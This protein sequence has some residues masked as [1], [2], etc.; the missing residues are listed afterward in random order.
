MTTALPRFISD[1]RRSA[2]CITFA[3]FCKI[4]AL[5]STL[6]VALIFAS[7]FLMFYVKQKAAFAVA[8]RRRRGRLPFRV[9]LIFCG[10]R[11]H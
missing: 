3:S 4:A 9:T 7:I 5:R 10:G 2:I 11:L 1:F 6:R 8:T